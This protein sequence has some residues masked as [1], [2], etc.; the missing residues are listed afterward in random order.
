MIFRKLKLSSFQIILFGFAWI[1]VC[2]TFLLMLPVSS[3]AGRWTDPLTALFTTTSA[4]CV[5]GLTV[6]D[7]AAYWSLTGKVIILLLIQIGGLGVVLVAASIAAFTGRRIGLM[8]RNILQNAVSAH[9][10]GGI[11]RLMLFIIRFVLGVEALGA[12]LLAIRFIPE[13]GL[14]RGIWYSIFHSISAFCNAGF[15]ILGVS[16]YGVSLMKYCSSPLVLF[17]IMGLIISGGLGFITWQDLIQHKGKIRKLRVQSRL[18]LIMTA[19]LILLP[20]ILLFAEL[21]DLPLKER[22]LGALFQSV[23]TRTAGFNS[24]NLNNF[25]DTG[26]SILTILMLIGAAPGSTAGGMKITTL[27]VLL[28]CGRSVVLRCD[29][30]HCM[31]HRIDMETVRYACTVCGLYLGLFLI[32]GMIISEFE[33]LSLH[34]CL[35]ETASAIG[36]VGLSLGITGSLHVVSRLI[37]IFLMFFGRVGSLT[38]VYAIIPGI[39][40]S[41]VHYTPEKIMVG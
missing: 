37:L 7:T 31:K 27:A 9:Q 29:E 23:T 2:G 30:V 40:N 10:L 20:A 24:L 6:C 16:R 19:S 4:V 21:G 12:A 34:I 26:Q 3:H 1:I 17:V 32:S 22:L 14:V 25:N 28:L 41:H 36:T 13:Y 38:L 15:D 8:Q 18:I 39:T 11:V 5:T 33:G 35:F